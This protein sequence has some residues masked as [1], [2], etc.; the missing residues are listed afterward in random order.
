ML[1]RSIAAILFDIISSHL[2]S[3][4]NAFAI[5]EKIGV[6]ISYYSDGSGEKK[7][8]S[9]GNHLISKVESNLRQGEKN[10]DVGE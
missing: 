10:K 7:H 8:C 2:I 5:E 9:S 3:L 6:S 1:S 4:N